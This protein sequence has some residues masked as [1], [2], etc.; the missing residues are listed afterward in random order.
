R[1]DFHRWQNSIRPRPIRELVCGQVLS[2]SNLQCFH[3]SLELLTCIYLA[4]A[5]YLR[6]SSCDGMMNE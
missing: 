6:T 3:V 2:Q 5:P 1:R 4:F